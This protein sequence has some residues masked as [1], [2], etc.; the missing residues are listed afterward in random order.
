[1]LGVA[2]AVGGRGLGLGDEGA[3]GVVDALG[4]G[5]HAVALL[6]VDALHV[7]QELI[8]VEVHLGQVH[9]IGAGAVGG[10]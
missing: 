5:H 3:V 2:E 8:H 10:G 1:Q 4:D 7:G 6:L 9:Q